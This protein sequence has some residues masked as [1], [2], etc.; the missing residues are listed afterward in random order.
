[1]NGRAVRRPTSDAGSTSTVKVPSARTK[2]KPDE[3]GGE[4][5][6]HYTDRAP[7]DRP[8]D[9]HCAS[10]AAVGPSP[11]TSEA[12]AS[13]AEWW[14]RLR[15][16]IAAVAMAEACPAAFAASAHEGLAAWRAKARRA[17]PP[18]TARA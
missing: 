3:A 8:A 9:L 1:M 11:F 5:A 10:T 17:P 13:S 2:R 12:L 18:A 16:Q 15:S 4:L 6:V 7:G 14:R